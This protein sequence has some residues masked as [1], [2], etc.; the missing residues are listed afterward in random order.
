MTE[1]LVNRILRLSV[2]DGPGSRMAVFLQG[3]NMRCLYC[4]N[5]E[6]QRTCD[7]CGLCIDAC[8]HGALRAVAGDVEYTLAACHY[9]DQCLLACPKG[10][11]PR[12]MS[13]SAAQ[14]VREIEAVAAFIDGVTLSGGE[15]SMQPGFVLDVCR[16]VHELPRLTVL[17]DTN[18]LMPTEVCDAFIMAAD[19]FL[20]DLKA[21]D[22]QLHR[23]LTGADNAVVHDNVRRIAAAGKLTEIRT[24]IVPGFNDTEREISRLGEWI[25]QLDS[26]CTWRLI[27]FRPQGVRACLHATEPSPPGRFC[28]LLNLARTH[29]T[30]AIA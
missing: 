3:C 4:H 7:G 6:T 10:S 17:V 11:S 21:S 25:C 24:V 30:P 8:V 26:T 29:Y 22:S 23:D 5:P 18:A 19:G 13:V 9:C 28:E 1:G 2:V 12:C 14:L 16:R 20:V 27:P 15:C